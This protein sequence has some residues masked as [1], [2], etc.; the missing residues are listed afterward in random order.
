M[1]MKLIAVLV[2]ATAVSG[3]AGKYTAE[4]WPCNNKSCDWQPINQGSVVK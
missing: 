4:T 1:G 3:C 2:L